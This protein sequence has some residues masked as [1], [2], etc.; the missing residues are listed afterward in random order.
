MV[1]QHIPKENHVPILTNLLHVLKPNGKILVQ[2]P[3]NPNEYYVSTNFVNLYTK[4]EIEK[5]FKSAGFDHIDIYE[6]NL[7]A[8]GENG[9]YIPSKKIEYFVEAYKS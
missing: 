9:E 8:Y 6:D 4:E 1:F 3:Q 7:V 2:F 5:I